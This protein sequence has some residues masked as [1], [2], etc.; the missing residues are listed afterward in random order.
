LQIPIQFFFASLVVPFAQGAIQFKF[1]RG[2][3]GLGRVF[4]KTPL[5]CVHVAGD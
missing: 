1:E 3:S 2:S 5:V 4:Q